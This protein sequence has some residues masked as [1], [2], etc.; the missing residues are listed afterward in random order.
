MSEPRWVRWPVAVLAAADAGWMIFDGTRALVR[1]DYVTTSDGQ[2]GPWSALVS[3]TGVDP[4]GTGMK[5]FFV[6]YGVLWLVG[7]GGYLAK[8]RWGR[9]AVTAGAAGS[10][11]YLVAGTVSSAVQLA[12]LLAGGRRR[13]LAKTSLIGRPETTSRSSVSDS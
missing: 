3:A 7:V 12:L 2:L 6:S 5:A 9:A 11:W 10:L 4:R 8:R 1:G 13:Y